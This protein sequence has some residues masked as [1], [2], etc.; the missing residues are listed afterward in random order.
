V[1]IFRKGVPQPVLPKVQ[2]LVDQV[3]QDLNLS[4]KERIA[5][6]PF[7]VYGFDVF[8]AGSTQLRSG[9]VIGIPVSFT[10]EE[11][12]DVDRRIQVR[13]PS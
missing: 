1:P 6:T 9:A 10:Y 3:I 8:H 7:I 5:I 13:Y 4:K 12:H 2:R 11:D